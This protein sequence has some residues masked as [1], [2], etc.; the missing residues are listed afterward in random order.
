MN[1]NPNE[2]DSSAMFPTYNAFEQE[3]SPAPETQEASSSQ[4][5]GQTRPRRGTFTHH[6]F[7][8]DDTAF[9]AYDQNE[10][11][12]H[13]AATQDAHAGE[14]TLQLDPNA[15]EASQ[16]DHGV[17]MAGLDKHPA[18]ECAEGSASY[19]S[20]EETDMDMA[21][22]DVE[23]SDM[24]KIHPS[25]DEI[26]NTLDIA[27]FNTPSG[28]LTKTKSVSISRKAAPKMGNAFRVTK[29]TKK[30]RRSAPKVGKL[31]VV[32][33]RLQSYRKANEDLKT[34]L[35]DRLQKMDVLQ[36]KGN[37]LLADLRLSDKIRSKL[38]HVERLPER[39]KAEAY[40]ALSREP[41]ADLIAGL[42]VRMAK[43]QGAMMHAQAKTKEA[44]L[45]EGME[46]VAF[47]SLE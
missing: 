19:S 4:T 31:E 32:K 40:L 16:S 6:D 46:D 45:R 27:S 25:I 9:G 23:A 33:S 15:A 34:D 42:F 13:V 29:S 24:R 10:L 3:Q 22:E 14:K 39:M 12:L 36:Q 8:D 21:D 30:T 44:Q 47:P 17:Y 37:N 28:S 2:G 41:G 18:A 26:M 38:S 5:L 35:L 43:T 7:V 1:M 20:G 11:D